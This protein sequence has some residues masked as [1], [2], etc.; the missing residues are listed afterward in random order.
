MSQLHLMGDIR[1]LFYVQKIVTYLDL[2]LRPRLH[3]VARVAFSVWC[4]PQINEEN[5]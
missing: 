3:P 1:Q 2:S 5:R 4:Q